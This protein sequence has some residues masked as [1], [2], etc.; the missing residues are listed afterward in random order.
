MSVPIQQA[1]PIDAVATARAIIADP[2]K[3]FTM[4]V[5]QIMAVCKALV[6]AI[7]NPE[8][9]ISTE[10]ADAARALIVAEATAD[11]AKGSDGHAPF[12]IRIARELG[13]HAFK[14][15]FE[16]EFPNVSE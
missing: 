12:E 8:P 11:L 3:K 15:L 6:D 7:D 13:F 9:A 5:L 4:S 10:L 14:T 1:E 2:R 16:M